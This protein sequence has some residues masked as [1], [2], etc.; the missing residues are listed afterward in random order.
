MGVLSALGVD[1][2]V[3]PLSHADCFRLVSA[4]ERGRRA[5]VSIDGRPPVQLAC[6]V[7]DSDRLLIP[8]GTD[9]SLVRAAAGRPVSIEF[10]YHDHGG[11]ASWTVV[12]MGLARPM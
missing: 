10:T 8:T 4:P 5:M 1:V 12:G 3:V 11:Q 6:V 2:A 9:R 7:L